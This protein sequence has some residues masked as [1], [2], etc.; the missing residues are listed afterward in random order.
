[1]RPLVAVR[2]ST[3]FDPNFLRRHALLWPL[4]RAARALA[5]HDDFPPVEALGRVFEADPPVHF[6][7]AAPRRRRR[8]PI[9]ARALY[10][11]RIVL[12]GE[13][14]TRAGC[15]HDFMNVL[16]WGTFPRA[17]RALHS[18]QHRAIAA[19]LVPGARTL[20]AVRT[21]E[22]DALAL[23]DE[24]GVVVLSHKGDGPDAPSARRMVVFGHAVYES[25]VL[26]VA[27]AVVAA[28]ALTLPRVDHGGDVVQAVDRVL[29]ATIE[30][31]AMLQTPRAF[32]RA[33]LS[34]F[35]P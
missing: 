5:G 14:P 29:A 3:P 1:M 13:V 23:L 19:R 16:V 21:P 4:S 15:W 6:V 11:A 18:R 33:V 26:G 28:V 25:L 9:E 10:D 7:P 31:D 20:P 22:L 17:K 8:A 2:R 27:P 34:P 12:F 32:S 35:A 30:D 24:G